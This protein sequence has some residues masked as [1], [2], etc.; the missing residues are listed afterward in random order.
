MTEFESDFASDAPHPEEVSLTL[1]LD[2]VL[3]AQ[4]AAEPGADGTDG[5][6]VGLDPEDYFAAALEAYNLMGQAL[7]E[8]GS[9]YLLVG[10]MLGAITPGTEEDAA[11]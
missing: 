6:P 2:K 7:S 3:E 1:A 9:M 8:V 10:S 5:T 4:F 11:V